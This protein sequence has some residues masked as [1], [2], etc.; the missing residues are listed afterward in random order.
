MIINYLHKCHKSYFLHVSKTEKAFLELS[1]IKTE[2]SISW[3]L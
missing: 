2:A 3:P 1:Y